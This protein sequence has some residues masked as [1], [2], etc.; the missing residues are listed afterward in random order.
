[1]GDAKKRVWQGDGMGVAK[2]RRVCQRRERKR[3]SNLQSVFFFSCL[4]FPRKGI[5]SPTKTSTVFLV[6]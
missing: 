5:N 2:D 3:E 4:H 1:M 6:R